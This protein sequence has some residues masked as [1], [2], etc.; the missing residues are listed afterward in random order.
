MEES[1]F[2]AGGNP[3]YTA[4]NL[5]SN[6]YHLPDPSSVTS[7]LFTPEQSPYLPRHVAD[8]SSLGTRTIPYTLSYSTSTGSGGF[9]IALPY[10]AF[11]KCYDEMDM[12]QGSTENLPPAHLFRTSQRQAGPTNL[13]N[14]LPMTRTTASTYSSETQPQGSSFSFNETQA[15]DPISPTRILPDNQIS[16]RGKL[17]DLVAQVKRKLS[18][19][20]PQEERR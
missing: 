4:L 20:A 5:I 9:P 2:S 16:G 3:A 18:P 6:Q 15:L 17:P 13:L 10:Q 12:Q 11:P 8:N 19:L 14:S 1:A 7:S